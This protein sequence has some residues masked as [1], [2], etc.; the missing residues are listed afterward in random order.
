MAKTPKPKRDP[1]APRGPHETQPISED[2]LLK[3]ADALREMSS[4]LRALAAVV[5]GSKAKVAKLK[6][7]KTFTGAIRSAMAISGK[8]ASDFESQQLEDVTGFGKD[9]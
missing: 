1:K 6:S 3:V 7:W 2:E 4:R 5:S 8:F 9:S